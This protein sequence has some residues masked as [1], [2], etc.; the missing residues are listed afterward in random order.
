MCEHSQRRLG[1]SVADASICDQPATSSCH[2][3]QPHGA[4][5]QS[6]DRLRLSP[7]YSSLPRFSPVRAHHPQSIPSCP[8]DDAELSYD[9]TLSSRACSCGLSFFCCSAIETDAIALASR[10][11][12]VRQAA[13]VVTRSNCHLVREG[14]DQNHSSNF[15]GLLSIR[16]ITLPRFYVRSRPTVL[17]SLLFIRFVLAGNSGSLDLWRRKSRS[18][19]STIWNGFGCERPP[20]LGR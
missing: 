10:S 8:P 3:R 12:T 2:G 11:S 7:P 14:R 1:I 17:S 9:V 15:F 6:I 19:I 13:N 5:R 20:P 16:F 4:F 18:S